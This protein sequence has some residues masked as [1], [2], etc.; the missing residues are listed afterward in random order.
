MMKN[1]VWYALWIRDG[2]QLKAVALCVL[3]T[4]VARFTGWV[5]RWVRSRRKSRS[6]VV[7]RKD[8]GLGH[9]TPRS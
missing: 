4:D 9:K 3:R 2:P 7:E 5:R 1:M 6:M 8:T